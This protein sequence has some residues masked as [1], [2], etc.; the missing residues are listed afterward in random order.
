LPYSFLS[1]IALKMWA[2][3]QRFEITTPTI[4]GVHIFPIRAQRSKGFFVPDY[5]P[6]LEKVQV[7][8]APFQVN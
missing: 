1:D 3:Y 5:L 6:I 2:I 8:G 7:D 4:F